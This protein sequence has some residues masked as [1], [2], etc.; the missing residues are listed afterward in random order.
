MD[1]PPRFEKMWHQ[2]DDFEVPK[3][4]ANFCRFAKQF[5]DWADDLLKV[6]ERP[7]IVAINQSKILLLD[8]FMDW[9]RAVPPSHRRIADTSHHTCIWHVFQQ[10][11]E[12]LKVAELS[13]TPPMLFLPPAP[14]PP[15]PPPQIAG[16][17]MGELEER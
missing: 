9:L 3:V 7:S 14:P 13:L 5:S 2:F 17:F 11:Y 12:R 1:T 10:A 8:R 15:P 16:I 4:P 6:T